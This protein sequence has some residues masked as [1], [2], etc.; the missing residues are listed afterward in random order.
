MASDSAMSRTALV[1]TV[2]VAFLVMLVHGS[3]DAEVFASSEKALHFEGGGVVPGLHMLRGPELVF[4]AQTSRIDYDFEQFLGN[5]HERRQLAVTGLFTK[6]P[7]AVK[8]DRI[9]PTNK[10]RY[11]RDG[12]DVTSKHYWASVAFTGVY[13]YAIGLAWLLLGLILALLAC[14][15][16]C[17]HRE[18]SSE[19]Q[20]SNYYF[21]PRIIV[22]VLSLLAI[23]LFIA[24]F[25]LNQR[26]FNQTTK[27]KTTVVEAATLVTD[28]IHTVTSTLGRVE[29]TIEKYN[30][31]GWQVLNATEAKLNEQADLVTAKIDRNVRKFNNLINAVE[32]A[33][34]IILSLGLFLVVIGLVAAFL[35]W[36]RVFFLIIVFGWILTALAWLLFGLLFSLN[37]VALDTC[38]AL[39]EFLQAPANT[40]LDSFLPCVDS[41]TSNAALLTVRE[42]T[43]SIIQEANSTIIT[44]QRLNNFLGKGNGT[45]LSLCNPFGP[46]PDY[47]Y[48]ETCPSGTLPIGELPQVLEP[49]VCMANMTTFQCLTD[50]RFVSSDNNA[51]LYEFAQG[52][53]NLLNTVPKLSKLADC[54]FVIDT[55]NNFV[56]Q[57]CHPLNSALRHLWIPMLLLSIFLTILT[58]LWILTNHR[59][60]HQ[61]HMDTVGQYTGG[62]GRRM[63]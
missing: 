43:S 63:R 55:F 29:D 42:G 16:L 14:F 1:T 7:L 40:T 60:A 4:P 44:I 54:S 59:N 38:Q 45:I 52:S 24:L 13:G 61:R 50:G 56:N 10:F 25:I 20:S 8:S 46:P 9:D 15:R 35:R 27:V 6:K 21:I 49:Y 48:T 17:S 11:Y 32:I 31:P 5:Y 19:H 33:F 62:K 41:A 2:M 26:A 51:T 23:G 22:L 37:N 34:I 57:R 58:A 47:N 12:Y 18:R 28:T 30:I 3:S 39:T 36:R 53:Q